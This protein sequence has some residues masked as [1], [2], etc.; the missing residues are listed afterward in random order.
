MKL[1]K[2]AVVVLAVAVVVANLAGSLFAAEKM[3]HKDMQQMCQDKIKA[4]K[5]SASILQK[6]NPDLAKGL[7]DLAADKEK[8]MQEMADMKA[9]H[10]AKVKMLR[11][12]ASILQK[13]NPDLAKEL[14]D[15]SEHK[16][17]KEMMGKKGC[18]MGKM[19]H[20][21]GEEHAE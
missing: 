4:L 12:S 6:T 7:T 19:G 15:M 18:P 1:L 11:D 17:M 13:T 9:K 14:W 5:D 16:H 20:E 2:V 10:E 3:H 8:M 21:E